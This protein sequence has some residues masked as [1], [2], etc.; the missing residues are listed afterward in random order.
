MKDEIIVLNEAKGEEDLEWMLYEFMVKRANELGIDWAVQNAYGENEV[1]IKG[2]AYTVQWQ[3]VGLEPADYKE[4][5]NKETGEVDYD[6]VG[7]WSWEYGGPDFEVSS[8][9]RDE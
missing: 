5:Y 7:P 1:V 8:Y 3:Y 2:V 9:W 4:I 6:P